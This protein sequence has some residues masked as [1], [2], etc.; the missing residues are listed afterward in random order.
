MVSDRFRNRHLYAP[1]GADGRPSQHSASPTAWL[2]RGFLPRPRTAGAKTN[3]PMCLKPRERLSLG[4]FAE[5]VGSWL[6]FAAAKVPCKT[7]PFASFSGRTEKGGP[8]RPERVPMYEIIL[9]H[10][11]KTI[12]L[13]KHNERANILNYP[14]CWL[15]FIWRRARDSNPRMS[16]DSLHDFQSCSFDQLGQ[17]SKDKHRSVISGAL[18]LYRTGVKKSRGKSNIF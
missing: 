18:L 10:F 5:R 6:H 3:L 7:A 12:S 17:L 16:V 15:S 4:R 2:V 1:L 14:R 9:V 8:S 11:D 13:F